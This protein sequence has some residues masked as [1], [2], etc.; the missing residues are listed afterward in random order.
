MALLGTLLAFGPS[1]AGA[2]GV[3]VKVA[4]QTKTQAALLSTRS[5]RVKVRSSGRARVRVTAI[6]RGRSGLFRA[7]V[8]AFRKKRAQAKMI[9]LRLTSRGVKA[10][11]GCGVQ[12]VRVVGAYR[13]APG[14]KARAVAQRRLTRQASR[15]R[16]PVDPPVEPPVEPKKS[17]CDPLDPAVCLQPWPSNFHTRPADTPTGLRLDLPREA[18]P[19]NIKG[20]GIDPTDMNRADG[21]SPGNLITVKIPGVDTPAAFSNSGIVS[22][23]D[24]SQYSRPD[25]PVLVVDAETGERQMIWAELDSN[26][27]SV[28][29]SEAGPGGINV[30]P[31]NT[32]DVNLIIRAAKNYTPGH[33]YVV[34]L[35]NLRDAADQPVDAP[36][37]FRQCRDG[38]KITDPAVLYRCDTLEDSVFP[39]LAREGISKDGL[40]MAWDFTVASTENIT[41]RALTIRDDAFHRLGDDDLSDQ[42]VEGDSPDFAIDQVIDYAPGDN[43]QIM[44]QVRGHLTGV[45]CYLNADGCGPGSTFAFDSDDRLTW[46]P[47]FKTEVPFR[48][49]IPRSVVQGSSVVPARPSLYGHGLLGSLSQ[50]NSTYLQASEHNVLFC[51][52]NWAGF[53]SEDAGSVV[54]ALMD[55]SGFNKATDR[56]QQGFVNFFMVGRAMIH[57]DGF[58]DDPAFA[59]DPDGAGPEPAQSV[60]DTSHLYYEGKSQG[61]IMGGALTALSPDFTRAVL[62]VPGMNYSTLLQ[63]SVDFDEY[64]VAPGYGL[65]TNYPDLG[66]RQVVLSLM[67]LLW[68]RGEANGY[69]QRMTDDPLPNTPPPQVLM[70]VAVGDHQVANVSA[71]VEAR[72]AG[73]PIMMPATDPGRHWSDQFTGFEAIPSYPHG[74]SAFVYWD[75]GPVDWVYSGPE[76]DE[77]EPCQ[78]TAV[79][80]DENVPPRPEWGFGGDPHSYS[81]DAV[82]ARQQASDFKQPNGSINPCAGGRPC[83]SNGWAGAE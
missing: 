55:L 46:N 3:K 40:Y 60:I 20:V 27:T 32:E 50:V 52:V 18:M 68:D 43:P 62:N 79:A 38:A 14:K 39:V 16:K 75:G 42:V 22:I 6:H 78:G 30:D 56:M 35:R 58:A 10:L 49:N 82:E 15:C 61:G 36:E 47:A 12:P 24:L 4:V 74:G 9:R 59:V 8:V 26:P 64:A 13:R 5:L 51:A 53:S 19:K 76:C 33:R 65:Y 81:R 45:P 69:A 48:C 83:Y 23:D 54:Q 44:R 67:Q 1:E 17:L 73:I 28:S 63:R 80:P 70:K 37:P 77:D 29:P 57:P 72:T 25:Q 41:G 11:S 34:V 71:E 21:F 66:E 2:R 31:G 7:R